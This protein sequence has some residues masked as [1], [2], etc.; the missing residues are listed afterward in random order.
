M[1]A[2]TRTSKATHIRHSER[3]T[4]VGNALFS[5]GTSSTA[6]LGH[7][8]TD[9]ALLCEESSVKPAQAHLT[10]SDGGTSLLRRVLS[11]SGVLALFAL[12]VSMGNNRRQGLNDTERGA[13]VADT[14]TVWKVS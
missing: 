10:A 9:E 4:G 12:G 11:G 5:Y 7:H 14:T 1:E 13:P 8:S 2:T 6:S 3:V